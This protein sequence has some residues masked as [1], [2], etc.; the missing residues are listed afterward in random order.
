MGWG[1]PAGT[2]GSARGRAGARGALPGLLPS[3]CWGACRRERV[4]DCGAGGGRSRGAERIGSSGLGAAPGTA[5][6][7]VSRPRAGA[8]CGACVRVRPLVCAAGGGRAGCRGDCGRLARAIGPRGV[9][10]PPSDV[11]GGNSG[12]GLPG[13]GGVRDGPGPGRGLGGGRGPTGAAASG[14]GARAGRASTVPAPRPG[15][16]AVCRGTSRGPRPRECTTEP[17]APSHPTILG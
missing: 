14:E 17:C 9:M 1:R 10:C 11:N 3:S 8:L 13:A 4:G 7:G 2:N 16:W 12:F 15:M 6:A 5:G